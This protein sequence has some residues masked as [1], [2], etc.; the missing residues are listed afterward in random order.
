M[1]VPILLFLALTAF[2]AQ[3]AT[4]R[5]VDENGKVHYGDV[6]PS[7]V[8]S[9]GNAE[10]D[11]Q[12]RVRKENARGTY[13]PEERR[14]L[15]EARVRQEDEKRQEEAQRRRDKALL[16]TFV[17]EDEIDLSRDRALE[18]EVARLRGLSARMNAA[19]EKLTYA[20]GQISHY[21]GNSQK[22]PRVFTQMKEEADQE[23]T[24][25]NAEILKVES[26]MQD[27]KLR[28]EADKLRFRELKGFR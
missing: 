20:N 26:S 6:L 14:R 1:R 22:P 12:G 23:I 11:K 13:T 17:S 8:P 24:D 18:Q 25:V 7:Q 9:K 3:A 21:L 5:W 16:T 10:L 2:Q 28:A 27:I 15:E 4:Y 19:N